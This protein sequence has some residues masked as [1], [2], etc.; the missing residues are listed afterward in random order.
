MEQP[1]QRSLEKVAERAKIAPE[2]IR[3]SEEL[4]P[5]LHGAHRDVLP[6]GQAPIAA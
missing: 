5:G 4:G 6:A 1:G 3:V 2:R